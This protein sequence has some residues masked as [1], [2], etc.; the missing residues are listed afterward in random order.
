VFIEL[1]LAIIILLPFFMF[2]D[3]CD[4]D[5]YMCLFVN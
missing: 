1:S 3:S 4:I 2:Y 5:S